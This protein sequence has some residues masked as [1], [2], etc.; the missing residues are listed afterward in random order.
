[1][2]YGYNGSGQLTTLTRG[3]GTSDAL[4]TTFGYSGT[5]LIGITTP[6]TQATRT[7]TLGYDGAGRVVSLTSPVSGAAGQAGYTPA[8]TTSISYSGG[9]TQVVDGA[10]SSAPL[11][12][13]YT[14]DASGEALAVQDGLGHTS[15]STFDTDHDVLTSTDANANV[16]TNSYQYVGPTGSAGLITETV[17][18]PIS[19]YT[20]GNTLTPDITRAYSDPTTYV[21]LWTSAQAEGS[22]AAA[23][24][25]LTI[26]PGM[27]GISPRGTALPM[28][29]KCPSQGRPMAKMITSPTTMATTA[30]QK[31]RSKARS[32]RKPTAKAANGKERR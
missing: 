15:Q 10:G 18:P 22:T 4:T 17:R 21:V 28:P 9:T 26:S 19:A 16:T 11:T 5:Q 6:Y 32:A 20:V 1:V 14:L 24:R 13:T 8:Y 2:T 25:S 30:R 27:K 7:W 23:S 12:T 29:T 31:V 3:A